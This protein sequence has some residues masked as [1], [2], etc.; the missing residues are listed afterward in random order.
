MRREGDLA[1]DLAVHRED[2]RAQR[3]A[4][5]QER[6][7]Q[8]GEH[9]ED[10]EEQHVLARARGGEM[11]HES[12]RSLGMHLLTRDKYATDRVKHDLTFARGCRRLLES[13]H[14]ADAQSAAVRTVSR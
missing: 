14:T 11:F 13:V 7:R 8:E 5:G 10:G 4:A 2:G 12:L 9:G 3:R 6:E 1:A